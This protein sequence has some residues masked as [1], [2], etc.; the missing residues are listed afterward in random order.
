MSEFNRESTL[1]AQLKMMYAGP[2]G[3][4]EVPVGTYFCDCKAPSGQLVEIQTGSFGPLKNKLRHI[5]QNHT[6]KIVHP[7]IRNRYIETY[8]ADMT[9]IRK[10]RSPKKGSLWDLFKA[11]MHGPELAIH[12]NITIE[13]VAL[14][15]LEKRIQDGKGSWRRQG[16]SLSDKS[17][18][19]IHDTITLQYPDSYLAFIPFSIEERFTI[20]DIYNRFQDEQAMNRKPIDA[21]F[22][23]PSRELQNYSSVQ[24][25]VYVLHRMGLI[26]RVGKKGAFYLYRRVIG[27]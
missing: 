4:Q 8:S 16:I 12:K 18:L 7:I 3:E 27:A 14:D 19:H 2:D 23:S 24:R 1:H 20:R 21:A 10:R 25:A 15:I 26:Q 17:L 22:C 6:V 13:L 9:L 11:L 5:G